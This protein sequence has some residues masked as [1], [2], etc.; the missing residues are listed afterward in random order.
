MAEI[1]GEIRIGQ[2]LLVRYLGGTLWHERVP[3]ARVN[4]SCFVVVTPELRVY[5]EQ[6][7]LPPL[8]GIRFMG[9]DRLLPLDIDE[10]D[11]IRFR[12]RN[13][14]NGFLS[15]DDIARLRVEGRLLAISE[16]H[17]VPD[18]PVVLVTDVEA[19]MRYFLDEDVGGMARGTEVFPRRRPGDV[20]LFGLAAIITLGNGTRVVCEVRRDVNAP[21]VRS[22]VGRV[23]ADDSS[24]S[25]DAY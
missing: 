11:V 17:Y 15:A 6:L 14:P 3:L 10:D 12:F 8:S 1:Q 19:P 20:A 13:R 24:D 22:F 18:I 9:A 4:R 5:A 25:S 23:E 16:R 7:S 2:A 21:P